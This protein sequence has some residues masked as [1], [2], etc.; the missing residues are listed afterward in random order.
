M[1]CGRP[2]ISKSQ[3]VIFETN[4]ETE[5][6]DVHC[7]RTRSDM[8]IYIVRFRRFIQSQLEF[9]AANFLHP[10]SLMDG[11]FTLLT[12]SASEQRKPALTHVMLVAGGVLIRQHTTINTIVSVVVTTDDSDHTRDWRTLGLMVINLCY[13][14]YTFILELY[15]EMLA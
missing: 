2:S 7:G 9:A 5:A 4:Q 1:L 13:W 6:H 10:S 12:F 3:Q 15:S 11:L 14:L 8:F